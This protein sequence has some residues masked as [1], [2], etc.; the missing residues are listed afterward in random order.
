MAEDDTFRI[1]KRCSHQE[2]L[3]RV[4]TFLKE[5][6][7]WYNAD[8]TIETALFYPHIE[9]AWTLEEFRVKNKEL[10]LDK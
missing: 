8:V 4:F 10:G 2:M 9:D 1:L 7:R 3:T 5:R 6:R